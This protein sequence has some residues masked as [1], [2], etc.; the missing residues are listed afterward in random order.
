MSHGRCLLQGFRI[1]DATSKSLSL[2][3]QTDHFF[4][5]KLS[6]C[7]ISDNALLSFSNSIKQQ[8]IVHINLCNNYLT[9]TGILK[10]G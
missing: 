10:L 4:E 7:S 3:L 1:G 9:S 5:L 2:I 8:P 6:N